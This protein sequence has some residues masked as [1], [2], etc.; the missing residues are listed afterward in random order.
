MGPYG[1][2]LVQSDYYASK[3]IS[4]IHLN[5]YKDGFVRHPKDYFWSSYNSYIA[6]QDFYG[7]INLKPLHKYFV[8]FEKSSFEIVNWH[9]Q[10]DT[11]CNNLIGTIEFARNLYG[12]E[13][14]DKFIQ[15]GTLFPKI[16]NSE[17][18]IKCVKNMN[19]EQSLHKKVLVFCL[20]EWSELKAKDLEELLGSSSSTI[21]KIKTR[22]KQELSINKNLSKLIDKTKEGVL[23]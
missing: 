18:I 6:G 16:T 13:Y 4:Y 23:N 11:V 5:P 7:L 2:K 22:V 17:S 10:Q 19:L 14:V 8:S 15:S 9:P 21:R 12:D 3:L 20:L 1:R